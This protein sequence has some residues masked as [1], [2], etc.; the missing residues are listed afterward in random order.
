MAA[1]FTEEQLT[2]IFPGWGASRAL[3]L[4]NLPITSEVAIIGDTLPKKGNDNDVNG[5]KRF[6]FAPDEAREHAK[7]GTLGSI[8]IAGLDLTG[9]CLYTAGVATANAGKLAPLA[10]FAVTLMLYFF[11]LVYSEVVTAIPVNGGTYNLMLQVANKKVAGF[12]AALSILSYMATAIV[13]AFDAVVYLTLLWPGCQVRLITVLILIAFC[14]LTCFGVGESANVGFAMFTLHMTTLTILIIWGFIYGVQDNFSTFHDNINTPYPTISSS[15]GNE[16]ASNSG[17]ASLYFGYCSALLGIT[18]FETASN[19]CE[20]MKSSK[21]FVSTVNWMWIIVGIY[22]PLLSLI[23]MMVMPM[24]SIYDHS[25]DMLA[26]M[27]RKVGGH[28]FYVMLNLDAV[29]ILCGGV[30]TALVGVS[31]L[32]KRLASDH[33]LPEILA[34]TNSRDAPYVAIFTFTALAISLFLA[35]FDPSNPTAINDFGGVFAIAFLSVLISFAC[36]AVLL[37]MHRPL[38]ARRVVA[39]W[40]QLIVSLLAVVAGFIGNVILTPKVFYL[41]LAYLSGFIGVIAAMFGRVEL[42]SSVAWILRRI[43]ISETKKELLRT[44]EERILQAM[45]RQDEFDESAELLKTDLQHG[46]GTVVEPPIYI[47]SKDQK[48]PLPPASSTSPNTAYAS[49]R[50]ESSE[51]LDNIMLP[52][53]TPSKYFAWADEFFAIRQTLIAPDRRPSLLSINGQGTTASSHE[54]IRTYRT[55]STVELMRQLVHEDRWVSRWLRYCLL[56]VEA[57]VAQPFAY[58][59][60]SADPIALHQALEYVVNNEVSNH[61]Y[62]VHFVDDRAALCAHNQLMEKLDGM[63][64]REEELTL[65]D[66]D[67]EMSSFTPGNSTTHSPDHVREMQGAKW[68]LAKFTSSA[69]NAKEESGDGDDKTFTMQSAMSTL[70]AQVTQ[71]IRLVNIVDTL[72]TY[73]KV[74]CIVVRGM[75]FCPRAVLSVSE[76]LGIGSSNMIMGVPDTS[77]PFPIAELRGVRLAVPDVQESL[78]LTTNRRLR[79]VMRD[80][81][82]ASGKEAAGTHS[83]TSGGVI[84]EAEDDSAGCELTDEEDT[85]QCSRPPAQLFCDL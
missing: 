14:V 36:A 33:I 24:D 82:F 2:A 15:S 56:R 1:P 16:L 75:Y 35:I 81:M 60:K 17:I 23:S 49:I 39:K 59:C 5:K 9:S 62:V 68:L 55:E 26:I 42:I 48:P 38:L 13:S 41:F 18:G 12:V 3:A 46:L 20:S 40:Y 6:K 8:S 22:N 83:S 21:V 77:F 70:P 50:A 64:K 25:S 43:R 31:G 37:K 51:K 11:R 79:A 32:L 53:A 69:E 76:Y 4:Q 30:L 45:E 58:L 19:Y 63:K 29:I 71:L 66:G 78:R 27:A 72:Y 28:G 65:H 7:L 34:T 47:T 10:L 85:E 84:V 73:K 67:I 52:R 57:I 44:Q 80:S 74:S 61:I 54:V